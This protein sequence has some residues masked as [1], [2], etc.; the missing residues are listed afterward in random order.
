MLR[1]LKDFD[2]YLSQ[3]NQS[4][5]STIFEQ[6]I[7]EAFSNI[8]Y[9]PFYTSN[10]DNSQI[11]N[12]VVWLGSTN[13]L[14]KAPSEK[15]DAIAHC[16]DFH[17]VVEAT[18][19]TGTK[20]WSQEFAP[21]I[22]HCENL[23][24]DNGI[25]PRDA[26]VLVVCTQ[27]QVDT[28]RSIKSHPRQEYRLVPLEVADIARIL[29]TSILAFTLRHLELRR[30]FHS[31]CDGI[32]ASSSLADFRGSANDA[33]AQWQKDVLRLEKSVFIGV[34]SYEAMRRIGRQHIGAT[35]ILQRLQ[36]HPV[37]NQYFKLIGDKV[38][39]DAIA[40]ALITHSF[41]ARLGATYEDEQLFQPVPGVDFRQRSLRLIRAVEEA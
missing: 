1:I 13:P 2:G 5:W 36:R 6:L 19:K 14:S 40:D 4:Q 17:L 8:L 28:Y 22:R 29:Q 32:V 37:V 7:A 23:C 10:N 16:C 18:M 15:P 3:F 39:A 21:S 41:A 35:E 26:Y 25:S 20:Q 24:A 12:R 9:L 27:L 30:L 34:K 31:I 38:G 33:M 11:P